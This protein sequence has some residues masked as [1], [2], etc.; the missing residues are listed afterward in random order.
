MVGTPIGNLG[1]LSPRAADA[2]RESDLI[3]AEDTR[4]AARLLASIGSRTPTTSFNEHNATDRLPA[5]LARL[6]AGETIALTT[7]AGMPGVSDPGASLVVAARDSGATV[8]VVPGPS[9]VA[10]AF[11]VS[12]IDAHGYLFFGFLPSRPASARREALERAVRAAVLS[13]LPIVLF[14]S[15]HRIRP[16]LADLETVTPGARVIVCR[17]MTKRHEEIIGGS[18]ADVTAALREERGEFTVVV[19]PRRDVHAGGEATSDGIDVAG[20]VR[21]ARARG[22][23]E[24]SVVDL[25]R[26]AGIGRRE[27]YRL[28]RETFSESESRP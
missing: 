19:D 14:E 16:L 5:L 13:Q 25:L 10:A 20:L 22:L 28:A 15:P 26:A 4:L 2:L 1:D 11:A 12:G 3:V 6:G 18:P 17:E 7:D 24:R 23:P 27:A 8:E 9:A 21:A